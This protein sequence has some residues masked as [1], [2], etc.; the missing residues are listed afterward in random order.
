VTCKDFEG[1]ANVTRN[2]E[3][4][5][6]STVTVTLC[7]NKTTGFSWNEKAQVSDSQVLQQ[8][9]YKW[10]PPQETGMVGTAGNEVWTF[11]GLKA[12]ASSVSLEYSQPW[13]GGKKGAWTFKLNVTIK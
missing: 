9:D 8:A 3:I 1:Q 10:I 13:D 12:G 7:S 4:A 5:A 6:G 2:V 11:R